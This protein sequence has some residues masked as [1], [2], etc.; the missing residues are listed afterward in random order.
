MKR[1]ATFSLIFTVL[2]FPVLAL[3]AGLQAS[4]PAAPQVSD[5]LPPAREI[6]NR[7][8]KAIGG[9]SAIL[10]HKFSHAKGR[11]EVVGQFSGD[12]ELFAAAPNRVLV[13]IR[14]P[15]MGEFQT[16]FDGKVGWE[17]NPMAG[18]SLMKGKKLEQFR[19][20]AEFHGE[21]HEANNFQQIET[22]GRVQF[23]GKECYKLRLVTKSGATYL[24]FFDV[25]SYLLVG[26]V[27]TIETPAGPTEATMVF[28]GYKRFGGVL[29]ATEQSVR[30]EI[31]GKKLEEKQTYT[32]IEFNRVAASVFELSAPVKALLDKKGP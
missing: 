15:G 25:E 12:I 17:V 14:V 24:K 27:S 7:F 30:Y 2:A 28:A 32:S 3:A 4:K 6:I 18:A 13:K 29:A 10:K 26:R 16:G 8:I 9:R 31:A 20:D 22:V 5:K 11:Y 1:V 19:H 21:L 23:E